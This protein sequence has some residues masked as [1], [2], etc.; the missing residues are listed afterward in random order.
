MLNKVL[1]TFLSIVVF[2]TTVGLNVFAH[3]CKKDGTS[4]SYVI[5][6]EHDCQKEA[7]EN[8][9]CHKDIV[10]TCCSNEESQI[11]EDCCSDQVKFFQ[12]T[13]DLKLDKFKGLPSISFALFSIQDFFIKENDAFLRSLT[14]YS[15]ENPP[16][17]SGRDILI[18]HQV[19]RI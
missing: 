9:C 1:L 17:K 18:S 19:F 12:L 13:S 7:I 2:S 10:P 5:P 4:I 8:S 15:F 14:I 6:I 11:K 3:F 16:P